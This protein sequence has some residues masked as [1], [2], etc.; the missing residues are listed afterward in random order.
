ML[1][2]F[3]AAGGMGLLLGLWFRMPVLLT[4]SALT[5]AAGLL[6]VPFK[7]MG[8]M[9]GVGV[10][11]ALLAMLQVGYLAG[12][13]V[14]HAWPRAKNSGARPP[15]LGEQLSHGRSRAR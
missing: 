1:W 4:A 3:A 8:A 10:T 13:V 15:V 11:Y 14:S 5:V 2:A 6:L 12:L 9:A 7:E